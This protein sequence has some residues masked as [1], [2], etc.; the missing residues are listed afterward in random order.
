MAEASFTIRAVDSTRQAFLNVQNSLSQLKQSSATAAAFMKRVF[1]PKALGTGLAAAFGISLVGALDSAVQA[2]VN[3][4][5]R[6]RDVQNMI[7]ESANEVARI[8]S[9]ASFR[10]MDPEQQLSEIARKR[11]AMEKE[12]FELKKKTAVVAKEI[13]VFQYQTGRTERV[14]VFSSEA[15]REEAQ[16][17]VRLQAEYANLTVQEEELRR[18]RLET[19]TQQA[20]ATTAAIIDAQREANERAA[21]E[22]AGVEAIKQANRDAASAILDRIDPMREYQ[23]RLD[24]VNRLERE[25]ALLMPQAE[26]ARRQIMAERDDAITREINLLREA[27]EAQRDILNPARQ[28]QRELD[29]INE[30]LARN[31]LTEDEA[32]RRRAQVNAAAS[33]AVTARQDEVARS[34]AEFEQAQARVYGQQ[35]SSAERLADLRAKEATMLD[36]LAAISAA[37]TDARIRKQGELDAIRARANSREATSAEGLM[38]LR[39][40]ETALM[41]EIAQIS[42]GNADARIRK[43][44]ELD[45]IRARANSREATSAEGL[46][47][48]RARETALMSEIAQISSDNADARIRKQGELDSIRARANSSEAAGIEGLMALRA[49][50]TALMAEIAQIGVADADARI[51]KQGELVQVYNEMLPLIEEQGRLAQDA[52]SLITSGFE[53]AIFS[54]EKLSNVLRNLALDLTR[55]VFRN[56]ILDPMASGVTGIIKGIF[57]M[58]ADGGPVSANSPFIVGEEGPEIFVP[59]ASGTIVPN[60]KMGSAGGGGGGSVNITYNIQSGVSRAELAPILENERKRLR[61]EIP[62]MVRRGGSYRAAFA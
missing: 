40:R 31:L 58:R 47:Q 51:R 41:S 10:A 17:L 37:D 14:Q 26:A 25:G 55:L 52:A 5:T 59:H 45:A 1:D 29:T 22:R 9:D 53:D 43:Q 27:A 38:Q 46:M 49:K 61:N 15:S 12:I 50:E 42:S 13:A 7:K 54:G 16:A 2:L 21:A 34:F 6:F 24:E 4:A 60:H 18:S 30:L 39:A 33:A 36:E 19:R 62:D 23:R 44:G 3:F 56:L 20:A 32:A 35:Q 28:Y 57:G 11:R 8:Y 48:L